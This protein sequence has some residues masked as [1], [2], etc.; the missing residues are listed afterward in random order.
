MK[1]FSGFPA[2]KL[3]V[4]PLPNLFFTELLPAIEDAAELKVTLHIFWLIANAKSR[5]VCVSAV[6]L[7]A[8]RTLMQSFAV[9]G[10]DEDETLM[11]ALD[12][13]VTR[14]TL[15]RLSS[16]EDFFYFVNSDSGRRAFEEME[17]EK[18]PRR[19]TVVEA[20]NVRER[21]NI[22]TLYEQN[23]GLLTPM[24]A[25]ELK[26]AEKQYRTD[27]IEDAFKIAVENNIRKWS[28][29]Q[30]ILE[31]WQTEGRAGD[32]KKRKKWWGDEYDKYI[33]R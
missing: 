14:G 13:A 5:S 12:A 3:A 15:L 26:E 6:E 7:R 29:V 10:R 30:K 9:D 18:M 27:W 22:F 32:S 1:I 19:S 23:V 2:G 31:R 16:D 17:K 11:R 28:Y 33:N 20:A 8:D 21:P 25:E 24:I 4:T